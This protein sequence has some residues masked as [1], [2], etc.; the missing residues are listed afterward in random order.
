MVT[1]QTTSNGSAILTTGTG[2]WLVSSQSQPGGWHE[3]VDLFD[4][5]VCD[6]NGFERRGHCRHLS[7]VAEASR[8]AGS[9]PGAL[10]QPER[11][12]A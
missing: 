1:Q 3:V 4:L 12:A 6:C 9:W 10:P 7:A 2:R 8:A 5:L 11:V